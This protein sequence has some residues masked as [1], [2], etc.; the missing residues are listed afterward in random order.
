MGQF[1][2]FS[3][4]MP[5]SVNLAVLYEA[6]PGKI[7]REVH[8]ELVKIIG[9]ATK[10]ELKAN[11]KRQFPLYRPG[12]TKSDGTPKRWQTPT[13]ALADS[14]GFK[15]VPAKKMRARDKLAIVYI[16]ARTDF[17]A[18]KRT[19][20]NVSRFT[21][22]G[23]DGKTRTAKAA[24]A[25]LY[26]SRGPKGQTVAPVRYFHLANKGHGPGP[27]GFSFHAKGNDVITPTYQTMK[28]RI[29]G[30]VR[31]HYPVRFE[32][33]IERDI[34]PVIRRSNKMVRKTY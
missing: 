31:Q 28:A 22:F 25:S 18:T 2:R 27:K 24:P 15:V 33:V 12:D 17:V 19:K 4:S 20:A 9:A 6:A 34:K 16:G 14:I 13:G 30:I 26:I 7:V 3:I 10:I 5:D 8:H 32:K 21:T 23:W 29:P 11:I 1:L